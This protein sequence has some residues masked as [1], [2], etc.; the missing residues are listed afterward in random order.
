MDRTPVITSQGEWTRVVVLSPS[1]QQ[2]AGGTQAAGAATLSP[3]LLARFTE[4]DWFAI[5]HHDPYLA[6]TELCL[7]ER[8][9]TA[10]AAWGLQRMEKIAL[11]ILHPDRW[12]ETVIA[13]LASAVQRC[14]PDAAV[15]VAIDDRI[16]VLPATTDRQVGLPVA[17]VEGDG[18]RVMTHSADVAK[19]VAVPESHARPDVPQPTLRLRPEESADSDARL[20]RDEIDMLL[21][22]DQAHERAGGSDNGTA[23]DATIREP[24]R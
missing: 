6:L 15:Y 5:E 3:N 2:G 13:D 22:E 16:D 20:S 23:T 1:P 11:V 14:L 7:R 12:P 8:A 24:R 21:H 9:Q 18:R 10:R 19:G 17:R 4:R